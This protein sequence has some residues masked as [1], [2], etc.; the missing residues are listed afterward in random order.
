MG[1]PPAIAISMS[2]YSDLRH[3]AASNKISVP[4]RGC[5]ALVKII[6]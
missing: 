3:L 2:G 4:L 6:R 1:M 5:L